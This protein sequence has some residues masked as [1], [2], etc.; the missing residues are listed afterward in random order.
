MTKCVAVGRVFSFFFFQ[1]GNRFVL[2]H[3]PSL[4]CSHLLF[5]CEIFGWSKYTAGSQWI[6][7]LF[8]NC[9]LFVALSSFFHLF[10]I[11]WAPVLYQAL[12]QVVEGP[13]W[14]RQS[15]LPWWVS[16]PGQVFPFFAL[17]SFV[18]AF[19]CP[20]LSRPFLFLT[21]IL[22]LIFL[23]LSHSFFGNC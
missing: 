15:G 22:S 10:S 13:Y 3:L 12:W 4:I 19:S 6:S 20:F 11:Y 2:I 17:F 8:P 16:S 5:S 23:L 18:H 14:T 21:F 7:C 9:S 1:R